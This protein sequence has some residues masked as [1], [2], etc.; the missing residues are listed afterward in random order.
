MCSGKSNLC[1]IVVIPYVPCLGHCL[2]KRSLSKNKDARVRVAWGRGG[3]VTAQE[4][5]EYFAA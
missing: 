2:C 5:S 4:V 1:A 3:G